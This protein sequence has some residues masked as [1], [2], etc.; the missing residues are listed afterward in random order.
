MSLQYKHMIFAI[1]GLSAIFQVFLSEQSFAGTIDLSFCPVTVIETSGPMQ[2]FV[3]D[4]NTSNGELDVSLTSPENGPDIF[5]VSLGGTV[6]P[7]VTGEG[8]DVVAFD[9]PFV[10]M[11][12]IT[13]ATIL[14]PN[15]SIS[16]TI[17]IQSFETVIDVSFKSFDASP[18]PSPGAG[19]LS[20]AL[21]VFA[22]A[23][24]RVRG[25]SPNHSNK[26]VFWF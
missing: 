2:F 15:G 7:S 18:G 13:G 9:L 26:Q 4:F 8:G 11:P 17:K 1:L 24:A 22:G 5:Q 6:Y 23:A 21:L 14:D 19:L 10:P 3:D 20:L 12:F 16:D 25:T